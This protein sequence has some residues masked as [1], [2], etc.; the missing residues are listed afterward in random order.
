MGPTARARTSGRSGG[1]RH[2]APRGQPAGRRSRPSSCAATTPSGWTPASRSRMAS[3]RA[4]TRCIGPW[5]RRGGG[6]G[7]P[8]LGVRRTAT[9]GPRCSGHGKRPAARSWMVLERRGRGPVLANPGGEHG[10]RQPIRVTRRRPRRSARRLAAQVS[11]L[12]THRTWQ[13]VT[14]AEQ[15][16]PD[17][18]DRM[19]PADVLLP[20]PALVPGPVPLLQSAVRRPRF[21]AVRRPEEP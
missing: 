9:A 8:W 7:P 5:R 10:V 20:A 1:V 19:V 18:L 17:D 16:W 14:L 21:R 3:T 4:T 12:A 11:R 2:E 13:L 6:N 15:Q